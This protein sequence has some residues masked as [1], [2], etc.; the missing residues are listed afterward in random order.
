MSDFR[1]S[2]RDLITAAIGP[3]AVEAPVLL[4]T[5]ANSGLTTDELRRFRATVWAEAVRIFHASGVVLR[6]IERKGEILKYPS[7]RP[8][9]IGLERKML[10]VVLA[11][12]VPL[13][14]D[15]G[16]ALSGV[17]AIYEG[18]HISVIAVRNAHANRFPLL[19]VNT[20]VHEL[21]H[22][23][24]GDIF[25]RRTGFLGGEDR[26]AAV[27]WQATGLWLFGKSSGLQESARTY[28]QRL[29]AHSPE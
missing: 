26:E 20:A 9:F 11:A 23:F 8:R 7:G 19:A 15:N 3:A 4:M 28:V 25:L 16:R 27:D 12:T 22:A 18:Y 21:L 1:I 14:W 6:A 29:T 5:D 10:N 2:R 24:R 17:T 13:E